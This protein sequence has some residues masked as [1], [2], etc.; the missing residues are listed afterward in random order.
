MRLSSNAMVLCLAVSTSLAFAVSCHAQAVSLTSHSSPSASCEQNPNITPSLR[1]CAFQRGDVRYY[2][3]DTTEGRHAR[4]AVV[5]GDVEV[6]PVGHETVR[7]ALSP[8]A[9]SSSGTETMVYRD[10][11]LEIDAALNPQNQLTW[12]VH[13]LTRPASRTSKD[14][15]TGVGCSGGHFQNMETP[16]QDM[17]TGAG[18]SGGRFRKIVTPSQDMCTG[19]DCSGNNMLTNKDTVEDD[20]RGSDIQH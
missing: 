19:A 3:I 14:M 15:C 5:D 7:I 17:C 1:I 18:C 12:I 11:T 6:L 8:K 10:A 16:A 13:P 9:P 20:T 2:H 4:L